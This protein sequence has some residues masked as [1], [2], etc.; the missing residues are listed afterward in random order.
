MI[1]GMNSMI[2]RAPYIAG[3][4]DRLSYL[5]GEEVSFACSTN[6]RDFSAEIAR[7]GGQRQ[8]V[9]ERKGLADH[10]HEVPQ[11]ASS[12]GCGWPQAFTVKIPRD[13]ASRYYKVVLRA[14]WSP[15]WQ[16]NASGSFGRGSGQSRSPVTWPTSIRWPSGSRM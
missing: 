6:A 10:A 15:L 5:P 14:S 12:Q 2:V 3:Y 16:W 9:W 8:I 1:R 4:P 7:V 13:W 11:D